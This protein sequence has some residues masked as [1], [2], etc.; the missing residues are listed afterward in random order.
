MEERITSRD[1]LL[2][3]HAPN[4]G[5]ALPN[6]G[7]RV[8]TPEYFTTMRVPLLSGRLFSESDNENGQRAAVISKMMADNYFPHGD[9]IGKR[10]KL[11]SANSETV[12]SSATDAND[13]ITVVGIVGDVAQGRAVDIPNHPEFYLS[14]RQQPNESR[15]MALLVRTRGNPSAIV[16]L[17]RKEVLTLDSQLPVFDVLTYDEI[18]AHVFGPKR[19]ALVL[20]AVF[21]GIALLLV[22]IGLY[23]II[24]YSVGQRRH[25]IG[26][27]ISVGAQRPDILKLILGHGVRL[28]LIGIGAGALGALMLTRLM[29][30][31]LFRVTASDPIIFVSVC[32]VLALT[33]VAA[34]LIPAQRACH[35]DPVVALR[36][37]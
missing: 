3:G 18:V 35:V 21:A 34:C 15:D 27:R 16:P 5:G 37:G 23:A 13:W 33:A 11:G 7:Y 10:F 14:Y 17:V 4:E 26:I 1:L 25:E 36:E 20:L 29:S 2:E 6:A 28:T 30:S 31:L 22:T 9:A 24:A 32:G 12:R 8:I 19:L